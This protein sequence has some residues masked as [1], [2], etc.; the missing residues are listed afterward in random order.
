MNNIINSLKILRNLVKDK[1]FLAAVKLNEEHTQNHQNNFSFAAFS[2]NAEEGI[3]AYIENL[4]LFDENPFSIAC[5]KGTVSQRLINAFTDDIKIIF[6]MLK[7]IPP[8]E[9]FCFGVDIPLFNRNSP[10]VTADNLINFY[11]K[12]GYGKFAKHSA[13]IY[14][15]GQIEPIVHASQIQLDDL[16]DY[17]DEK[18]A[19][20]NNV[21]D[22]LNNLPYSHTL[23]YGDRGTGKSSTI[24]AVLNRFYKDGLR[25]IEVEKEDLCSIKRIRDLVSEIPLKFIIF[26]DDLTFNENDNGV[27]ALKAAVEGSLICGSNSMIVAT[28]NRRHIVSESFTSRENSLHPS[29]LKEDQLS[30][31]DRFGLTVIFSTTDKPKYLSIVRQLAEKLAVTLATEELETLAER[32]AVIKG[33]RSP[34]RAE[35]F[36][37]F[38]YSCQKS[39]REIEF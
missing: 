38:I 15:N 12:N 34:R 3:Y 27:S 18:R 29:D 2:L 23:L 33:G 13:F 21:R 26:T 11:K 14:R 5:A 35:Q 16:K 4:I 10:T 25:L 36:V 6:D 7:N 22:F 32:W 19:I 8:C 28:S 24:H 31:S 39:G 17:V 30:L 20:I 1:L 9:D 37:N